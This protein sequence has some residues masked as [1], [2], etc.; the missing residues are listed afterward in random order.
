MYTYAYILFQDGDIF[1]ESDA[2]PEESCTEEDCEVTDLGLQ[3]LCPYPPPNLGDCI[4]VLHYSTH[5]LINYVDYFYNFYTIF[6]ME[7][8]ILWVKLSTR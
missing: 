6:H 1:T 2:I 5:L 8:I 7:E 3:H 4:F